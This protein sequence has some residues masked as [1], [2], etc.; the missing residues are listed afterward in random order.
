[1]PI[2]ATPA[3]APSVPG[4]VLF[5]DFDGVLQTPACGDWHEMALCAELEGLLDDFPALGLVVCST[6]RE[7][8]DLRGVARLLPKPLA[9]RVVGVTPVQATGRSNGG[10]QA[11]IE[12]WLAAHPSVYTWAAVDDEGFLYRDSCPWLVQTNKYLG[13]NEET[14][15][16]VRAKLQTR[17]RR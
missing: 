16:A 3:I 11:E 17:T 9:A 12:T 15:H 13:W 7:G 5:L 1:M 2:A 14:T 8:R 6:H 10:R 4:V